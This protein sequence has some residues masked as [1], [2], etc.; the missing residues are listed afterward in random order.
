MAR[1]GERWAWLALFWAAGVLAFV[2]QSM[3]FREFSILYQGSELVIGLFFGTWLF[4]VAM[5]AAGGRFLLSRWPGWRQRIPLIATLYTLAPLAQLVLLRSL[6]QLVGVPAWQSFAPETLLQLT[7]VGNAPVSLLTGLL[8]TLACTAAD[9]R[10]GSGAGS[11]VSRRVIAESL[12]S[13]IGGLLVTALLPL[14]PG[15]VTMLLLGVLPMLLAAGCLAM[16]MG[17]R[18]QGLCVA[19]LVLGALGLWVGGGVART[20]AALEQARWRGILPQGTLLASCA[21]PYGHVAVGQLGQQ[22]VVARDGVLTEAMPDETGHALTAALLAGQR[23]GARRLLLMGHG[24]TGLLRPLLALGYEAVTWLDADPD[25]TACLRPH[26]SQADQGALADPRLT[27][28]AGDPRSSVRHLDERFDLIAVLDADPQSAHGNRLHTVE[29]LRDLR[30]RLAP[31]GLLA[32]RIDAEANYLERDILHLSATMNHTLRAVFGQVMVLP[33]VQQWWFASGD[34][35]PMTADKGELR[36]R[37]ADVAGV[38]P[39]AAEH[40]VALLQPD[41]SAAMSERLAQLPDGAGQL[42]SDRRPVAYLLALAWRVRALGSATGRALMAL[43]EAGPLL[44]LMP[45]LVLLLLRLSHVALGPAAAGPRLPPDPVA[46]RHGLA[47]FN[48]LALLAVAGMLGMSVVTIWMLAFQSR[49]G[50]I[51]AQLGLVGGLFVL[52]LAGGGGLTVWLLRRRQMASRSPAFLPWLGLLAGLSAA[53]VSVAAIEPTLSWTDG[54]APAHARVVFLAAFAISG[55]ATGALV[56]L[57]EAALAGSG[58]PLFAIAGGI[59]AA[60]HLGGALAAFAVGVIWLPTLGVMGTTWVLA[61]ALVAVGALVGQ[62]WWLTRPCVGPTREPPVLRARRPSW[63]LLAGLAVALSAVSMGQLL[64]GADR[65]AEVRFSADRLR[66][67]LEGGEFAEQTTPFAH[68]LIDATADQAPRAALAAS[69]AIAPETHGYAGPINVLVVVAADG[70]LLRVRLLASRDT[71]AYIQGIDRWLLA[72]EGR[73]LRGRLRGRRVGQKRGVDQVDVLTGATVTSDAALAAINRSASALLTVALGRPPP[74]VEEAAAPP[75]D[76]T[77]PAVLYL[78]TSLLLAFACARYAGP[79]TRRGLLLLHVLVGGWWLNCQ[80]STV[81]LAR[82]VRLEWPGAATPTVALLFFG[83]LGLGLLFGPL[84]CANMCPFGAAQELLG[85]LGLAGRLHH[86]LEDHARKIKYLLLLVV[87]SAIPLVAELDLL[88]A[89]PLRMGLGRHATEAA[90][91]WLGAIALISLLVFRPWCRYLCPVGAALHLLNHTRRLAHWLRPRVYGACDLGVD[92][93]ADADCL[94]CD[95]CVH[96]Q[97]LP[98]RRAGHR[99]PAEA[100]P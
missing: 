23:P 70:R 14:A 64:G 31:G 16:V 77:D 49:F 65:Q 52:G 60:D 82:F 74:E 85:S 96:R 38:T 83:A 25:A 15:D 46:W 68:Y 5:G 39:A 98:T 90:L 58:S 75:L 50:A 81:E 44:W 54:L 17:A 11:P 67:W 18:G 86:R 78:M 8:F 66:G 99:P 94:Q 43:R 9:D 13:F 26:L 71:P 89:D 40:A 69:M 33:G 53:F 62:Q 93:S 97:T 7:L 61:G 32:S 48:A 51:F 79:M 20:E 10:R 47:R 56:P 35:V 36:R 100:G 27:I 6:R 3:L 1:A 30:G 19:L 76:L 28:V 41:R 12:G 72:L 4:W 2:A 37:L 29:F 91:P 95:R 42:N 45:L 73:T 87:A 34:G 55:L 24:A 80:L 63:R 84:Y 57:A 92:D 59:E 22:T 21:T 88:A